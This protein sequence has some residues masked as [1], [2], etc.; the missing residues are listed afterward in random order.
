MDVC[1][2]PEVMGA[3][4]LVT[5]DVGPTVFAAGDDFDPHAHASA[6]PVRRAEKVRFV[7]MLRIR[8]GHFVRDDRC[9][10]S[11]DP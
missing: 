11:R 4:A 1:A 3:A 5:V 10:F 2:Q 7:F 8:D 6:T 9:G